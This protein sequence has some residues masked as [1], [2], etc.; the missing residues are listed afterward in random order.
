M[1]LYQPKILEEVDFCLLFMHTYLVLLKSVVCAG[2]GCPYGQWHV[3]LWVFFFYLGSCC[4]CCA[5]C[6]FW[7]RLKSPRRVVVAYRRDCVCVCVRE[8]GIGAINSNTFLN[9]DWVLW[10]TT[11]CDDYFIAELYGQL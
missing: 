7:P 2:S 9:G 4:A 3:S 11:D 6:A 5:C 10:T 1:G 8:R